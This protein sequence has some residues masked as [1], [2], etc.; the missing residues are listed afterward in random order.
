MGGSVCN[1][2][3]LVLTAVSDGDPSNPG[4]SSSRRFSSSN[5]SITKSSRKDCS[6]RNE[7]NAVSKR[8][9]VYE[10]NR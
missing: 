5:Y 2:H 6:Q 3:Y 1:D 9:A 10:M 4:L 7:V 8:R